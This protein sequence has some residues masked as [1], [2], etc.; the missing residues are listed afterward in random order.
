MSSA[1]NWSYTSTLTIW[2]QASE[3]KYGD[4]APG[5]PYTIMGSWEEGG[6][7]STDE[8]G[9]EFMPASTYHFESARDASPFPE[10]GD[11]IAIGDHTATADPMAA[12]AERIRKV[13]GWDM[14]AFGDDELPD[15][16]IQT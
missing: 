4:A 16:R 11:F 13:G 5:T 8:T 14:S 12:N 3:D 15:W 1:A 10:R 2:P 6:E 9:E 7:M